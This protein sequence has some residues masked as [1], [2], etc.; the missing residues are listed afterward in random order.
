MGVFLAIRRLL[1]AMGLWK[2]ETARKLTEIQKGISDNEKK[3]KEQQTKLQ[4]LK[5]NIENT[6]EAIFLKEK[7]MNAQTGKI[8]EITEREIASLFKQF[9]SFSGLR[10]LIFRNIDSLNTV[11]SKFKEYATALESNLD[12]EAIAD[13]TGDLLDSLKELQAQDS[14]I[15][16]LE[17]V[18]YTSNSSAVDV[19]AQLATLHGETQAAP[20]TQK[21][22][23]P[24]PEYVG[25][26][27]PIA[28]SE[29][30]P[31]ESDVLNLEARLKGFHAENEPKS[32]EKVA[33]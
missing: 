6:Q 16:R 20:Q 27:F 26:K 11:I 23:Q 21:A 1:E 13:M 30:V 32:A 4:T 7:E 33:E 17:S 15:R 28:Q 9:D 24:E 18:G 29:S 31:T 12:S 22:A 3:L 5:R 19:N 14:A 25:P 10:D 2:T 8:R